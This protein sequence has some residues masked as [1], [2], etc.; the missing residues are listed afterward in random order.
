[1]DLSRVTPT[2]PSGRVTD[3]DVQRAAEA[4]AGTTDQGSV[5][6][7]DGTVD[8]AARPAPETAPEPERPAAFVPG[9]GA[10][11]IPLLDLDPLPDFAAYGPIRT[12]PLRSIRRKTARRMVTTAT[13]V[14]HV[15]HLDEI[16][17]TTLESLRKEAV[18][19]RADRPGGHLTLL[20]F[21]VKA[22]AMGLRDHPSFNASVDPF[23]EEIVFKGYVHVGVALDS[24]RGLIVPVIR[25]A[26]KR[27][28][29]AI[30]DAVDDL[31]RRGREGSLA[32][33]D[34][35]GG[36]FTI[37]NIGFLG[38]TGLVPLVNYPE[39]A[40]LG[41][42]RA[43]EKPVVRGGQVVVRTMLPVTLAFDHRVADGADAARFVNDLKRRLE[44][45]LDLFLEA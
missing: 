35:R 19:R 27:S 32:A 21:V 7:R 20:A 18:A 42:A 1:V 30:A 3:A 16:D 38:G 45:P 25:D 23:R 8:A 36:T 17:V 31:A 14:P 26:E 22:A 9:P 13:L 4:L 34:L 33:G 43:R 2:G 12:E 5:P 44:N 41:L 11:P 15:A 37:T 28:I 10:A 39:V 40:I 24:G 29:V 6:A